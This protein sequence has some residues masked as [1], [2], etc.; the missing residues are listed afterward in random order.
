[1]GYACCVSDEGFSALPVSPCTGQAL[2][3]PLL[4]YRA[5][6]RGRGLF[7]AKVDLAHRGVGSFSAITPWLP[8]R[9][10]GG[11]P[12]VGLGLVG[13]RGHPCPQPRVGEESPQRHGP[14]RARPP[15]T[16]C[17]SGFCASSTTIG[18]SASPKTLCIVKSRQRACLRREPPSL[19]EV[20]FLPPTLRPGASSSRIPLWVKGRTSS[21]RCGRSTLD[22]DR[23]PT[24]PWACR[25][26]DGRNQKLTVCQTRPQP[27]TH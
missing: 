8:N 3:H 9:G 1:M 20:G 18:A 19:R 14:S 22:P 26:V 27:P 6:L 10:P 25:R 16:P 2:N 13:G 23:D 5:L 17:S 4:R 24:S 21:L 11:E 12:V 7:T 15:G